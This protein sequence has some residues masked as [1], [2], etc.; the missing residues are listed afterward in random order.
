MKL[1]LLTIIVLIMLFSSYAASA[2]P[3]T[4]NISNQI[5]ELRYSYYGKNQQPSE[6]NLRKLREIIL[7]TEPNE[8]RAE[9]TAVWGTLAAETD[10]PEEELTAIH[11]IHISDPVTERSGR[12]LL[13]SADFS[14]AMYYRTESGEF[15]SQAKTF[16]RKALF[17]ESS[18]TGA[19]I[20]LGIQKAVIVLLAKNMDQIMASESAL[21]MLNDKD[22]EDSPD[23]I[24]R[25][26]AYRSKSRLYSKLLNSGESKKYLIKA[27]L[28]FP[29]KPIIIKQQNKPGIDIS[30]PYY[31]DFGLKSET[32][33][34]FLLA[35][36]AGVGMQKSAFSSS[37]FV[38][39]GLKYFSNNLSLK[40]GY[41]QAFIPD[42]SC[43]DFNLLESYAIA[44]AAFSSEG[45][46]LHT[47][48]KGGGLLN[49]TDSN[50]FLDLKSTSFTAFELREKISIEL[51]IAD[52]GLNKGSAEITAGLMQLPERS[53]YSWSISVAVPINIDLVYCELGF[54]SRFFHAGYLSNNQNINI[55]KR[56]FIYE[57]AII[58]SAKDET[59]PFFRFYETSVS[60]D[61]VL[62]IFAF[63]LKAPADRFYLGLNGSSGFGYDSRTGD[64][65]FLY[66]GGVSAGFDLNDNT[67]F[68]IRFGLDQSGSI[69]T[70]MTIVNKITQ[71]F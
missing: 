42:F 8:V 22:I 49:T 60:I 52:D 61:G 25:Y 51:M 23:D 11:T 44:E 4:G 5:N 10:F 20:R 58:L 46:I 32:S 66:A 35:P 70:Y 68:E 12:M 29:D 63:P 13:S 19:R 34:D 15:L 64:I 17:L 50:N 18:D 43:F 48:I 21:R 38:N 28:I 1:R 71:P 14:M 24:L 36:L 27:L 40:L 55:G 59:S 67:P 69:F 57:N 62:R 7:K 2:S 39:T 3:D 31:A 54:L 37:L 6:E 47:S 65:D 56:H 16:T 33:D 26:N 9:L 53:H 41:Q 45:N 30:I